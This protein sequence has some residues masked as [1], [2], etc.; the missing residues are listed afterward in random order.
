MKT[1]GLEKRAGLA[2]T[3]VIL[4]AAGC[5]GKREGVAPDKQ[6]KPASTANADEKS[7]EDKAAEKSKEAEKKAEERAKEERTLAKLERDLAVAME[8]LH[9]AE[10][11]QSHAELEHE[12]AIAKAQQ[13]LAIERKKLDTFVA[14]EVLSRVEWASHALTGAEDRLQE[15]REELEQLQQ[16]YGEDDFADG[17]KEI[18]LERGRKRLERSQRDYELRSADFETLTKRTIPIEISEREQ[19]VED[20]EH[21]LEKAR[22]AAETGRL[23][24]HIS[25]MTARHEIT[26]LETE[27]DAQR[28]KI[29]KLDKDDDAKVADGG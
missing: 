9:R 22:R 12:L 4:S 16:M 2:A 20:K 1:F 17:T 25:L 15:A 27:I 26:R 19:R 21:A 7:A 11:A 8:K 29:Q 13:E 23:D 10:M 28:K 14:K 18:V 3:L 24:Q 5:S 6:A